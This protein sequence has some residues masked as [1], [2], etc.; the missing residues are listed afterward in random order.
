VTWQIN[1][2]KWTSAQ[3]FCEKYGWKFKIV[4]EKELNI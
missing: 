3:R 4:T 1:N 2:A